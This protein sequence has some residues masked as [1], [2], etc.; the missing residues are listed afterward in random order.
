V[1]RFRT[2]SA[3]L[4]VLERNGRVPLQLNRLDG[5]AATSATNAWAVG[6]YSQHT[7]LGTQMHTRTLIEH[8]NGTAWTQVPS[9]SPVDSTLFGVAAA[10]PT[11]I[12]A[13]GAYLTNAG[14]N[15]TLAMQPVLGNLVSRR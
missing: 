13:V 6:Y 8:W 5:V 2:N 3:L 15:R 9:P 7:D 1:E 14:V 11:N 10:S 12:W 4:V